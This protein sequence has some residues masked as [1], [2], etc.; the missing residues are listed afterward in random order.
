MWSILVSADRIAEND[1]FFVRRKF[2]PLVSRNYGNLRKWLWSAYQW[3]FF[4][5]MIFSKQRYFETWKC[6]DVCEEIQKNRKIV[7][8]R[9]HVDPTLNFRRSSQFLMTN[10]VHFPNQLFSAYE[11]NSQAPGSAGMATRPVLRRSSLSL[12]SYLKTAKND[13]PW[14]SI[15]FLSKTSLAV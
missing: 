8:Y 9:G 2:N 12:A 1:F 14:N 11:F 4:Y 15:F 13:S 6:K 3:N 7:K 5:L 10:F